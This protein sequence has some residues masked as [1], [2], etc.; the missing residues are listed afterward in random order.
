MTWEVYG[1]VVEVAVLGSAIQKH[2]EK[3]VKKQKMQASLPP[4]PPLNPSA[5]PL[6]AE[7][8]PRGAG[9]GKGR[10]GKRAEKEGKVG[11]RRR[12]PFR[13]LMENMQQPHCCSRAHTTE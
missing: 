11:R 5:T 9:S 6:A 12:N 7:P 1:A 3:Q 4:P 13:Q 2:L 8:T 10:A